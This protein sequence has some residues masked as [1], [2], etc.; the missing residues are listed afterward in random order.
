MKTSSLAVAAFCNPLMDVLSYVN[1]KFL[2]E[3]GAK[4][5]TMNLVDV[6]Q[7]DEIMRRISAGRAEPRV[8]PGGSGA[9]TA[10]GF[11]WLN[12]D[13][14]L[15]P[16][17]FFGAVGDDD[18]GRR[19][20]EGLE[21]AGVRSGLADKAERTGFSVVA[22]TPDGE[23]TMFTHLGACRLFSAGDVDFS[24]VAEAR[25]LHLTGY[26]WDTD[27]QR[28]T[29]E[30]AAEEAA[31]SIAVVSLDLAD[32]FVVTRYRDRFVEWIPGRVNLL[33]GNR[34]EFA[35]LCGT[36]ESDKAILARAAEFAPLVIMK[37]GAR[38]AYL[39]EGG[40]TELVPGF[41][42]AARDTTGAGDSFAGAFLFSYLR[43]RP[44]AVCARDGNR[45]ASAVVA[46]E[47]CDYAAVAEAGFT[48]EAE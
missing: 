30:R 2:A 25:V 46:V 31:R 19:Y 24:L 10:R 15:P 42:V 8:L 35:L 33:F 14:S 32:P 40:R 47:G 6:K 44:P 48:V 23:R 20:R 12:R 39:V 3:W 17:I 1:D 45:L 27:N 34:E 7:A 28:L 11:A 21:R 22:V 18:L 9:N 16:S 4:P 37:V 43:G 5:G 13:S 26:M 29:A 41:S 36:Q 38:G